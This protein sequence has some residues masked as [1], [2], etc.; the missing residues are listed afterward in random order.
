MPN[1]CINN[2]IWQN[3][4]I[5]RF[6]GLRTFPFGVYDVIILFNLGRCTFVQC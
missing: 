4:Q 1:I 6:T 2:V 3:I 5:S